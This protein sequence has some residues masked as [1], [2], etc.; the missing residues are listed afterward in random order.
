L[1]P[2]RRLRGWI[3]LQLELDITLDQIMQAGS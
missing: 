2:S 3:R 1:Q